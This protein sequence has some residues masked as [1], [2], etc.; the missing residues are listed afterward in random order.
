MEQLVFTCCKVRSALAGGH[1]LGGSVRIKR[2]RQHPEKYRVFQSPS[3]EGDVSN[4]GRRVLVCKQW[5][6]FR[7]VVS[8]DGA[9]LG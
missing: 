4:E 8:G 3:G 1:E 7:S 6:H 9:P 2:V 5:R